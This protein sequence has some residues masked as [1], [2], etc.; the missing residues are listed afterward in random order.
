M[1]SVTLLVGRQTSPRSEVGVPEEQNKPKLDFSLVEYRG[2]SVVLVFGTVAR[3]HIGRWPRRPLHAS[4]QVAIRAAC[5][6]GPP[7]C[8]KSIPA[9]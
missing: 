5:F 8:A 9:I 7:K 1:S 4:R 2:E 6:R 3:P